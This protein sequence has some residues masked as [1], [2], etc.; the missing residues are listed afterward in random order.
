MSSVSDKCVII[1][2]KYP[3]PGR[4][5]TRLAA[6]IGAEKAADLYKS[7]VDHLMDMLKRTK[8]RIRIY[9]DPSEPEKQYR[10]WLGDRYTYLSQGDGDLGDR[11]NKAFEDSFAAGFARAVI[12]GSDSPDLP[13]E[14]L[15][16][17]LENRDAVIGPSSDGG[18]YLIGFSENTYFPEVFENIAWSTGEVLSETLY[19]FENGDRGVDLLQQWHDVD[20]LG[21]L[22][23][24]VAR[25]RGTGFA[26]SEAFSLACEILGELQ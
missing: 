23:K 17:T 8:S 2:V 18:Y 16:Q 21:D 1:F 26:D 10:G 19:K 12:I 20:T 13:I 5:K 4:V 22:K 9:F 24:L 25:N 6:D 14:L 3:R 15:D 11:M 7:F